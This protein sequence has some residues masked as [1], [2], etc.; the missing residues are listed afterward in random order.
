MCAAGTIVSSEKARDRLRPI[1]EDL[2]RLGADKDIVSP[3][4]GLSALGHYRK[5]YHGMFG[6]RSVPA[7]FNTDIEDLLMPTNGA[8]PADDALVKIDSDDE[9]GEDDDMNADLNENSDHNEVVDE[10][11]LGEEHSHIDQDMDDT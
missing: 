10:D 4:D 11:E 7:D 8:T 6:R 2:L 3:F 1:C 9:S 5:G